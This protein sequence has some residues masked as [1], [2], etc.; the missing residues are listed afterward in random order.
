VDRPVRRRRAVELVVAG[1]LAVGALTLTACGGDDAG[2]AGSSQ[3]GG[4]AGDSG[5]GAQSDSSA[6]AYVGLTKKAA[7]TKADAAGTTWRITREDDES[8]PVTLDYNPE[9]LNFEIDDGKV[10]QATYG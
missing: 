3:D 8:F 6:S 1:G 9:R 10:T 7:I 2:R 4:K 5:S